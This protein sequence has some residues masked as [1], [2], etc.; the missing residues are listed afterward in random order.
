MKNNEWEA[1]EAERY[2]EKWWADHGFTV[3][4]QSRYITKSNYEISKDG[5]TGTYQ[6]VHATTGQY[7]SVMM[8]LFN[9]WW[10]LYSQIQIMQEA[11]K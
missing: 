10:T 9:E 6:I 7:F 3:K 2:A 4:L 1:C 8:K 5:V 11:Q